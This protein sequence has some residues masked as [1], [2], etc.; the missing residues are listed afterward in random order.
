MYFRT[1]EVYLFSPIRRPAD[2]ASCLWGMVEQVRK[3]RL[4]ME[5]LSYGFTEFRLDCTLPEGFRYA[6]L[7]TRDEL[8]DFIYNV[9]SR[10]GARYG[11]FLSATT[12]KRSRQP[13]ASK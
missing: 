3:E 12:G 6:R 11:G 7:A 4:H 9:A 13:C 5:I 10:E 8:R 2:P 1:G